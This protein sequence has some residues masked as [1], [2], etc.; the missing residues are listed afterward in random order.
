MVPVIRAHGG[1]SPPGQCALPGAQKRA[2]S[3]PALFISAFY[4]RNKTPA[5][6]PGLEAVS[7][8]FSFR[9]ERAKRRKT[10]LTAI[11]SKTGMAVSLSLLSSKIS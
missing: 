4:I 1:L 8:S 10:P 2:G 9:R 11:P 5:V 3:S 6:I 7:Q